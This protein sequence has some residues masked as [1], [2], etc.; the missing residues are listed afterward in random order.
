MT[1]RELRESIFRI[2]FKLEFNNVEEMSEQIEFSLDIGL[3]PEDIDDDIEQVENEEVKYNTEIEELNKRLASTTDIECEELEKNILE[4][5][6]QLAEI[7][8]K[9]EENAEYIRIKSE[10]ILTKIEA[11][12]GIIE[13]VSEGWS[14]SRIGKP[15]LAILRLAIYEIN[16]DDEIPDSVAINE[17]VELSKIYCPDNAKSFINGVLA[18]VVKIGKE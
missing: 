2:L 12:D 17:A 16:Y 8:T 14:I 10:D 9:K 11:I 15:E 18:K 3:E 13:A 4:L 7:T 6:T 1:R 5:Q